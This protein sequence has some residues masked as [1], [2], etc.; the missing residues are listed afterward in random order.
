MKQRGWI[1]LMSVFGLM[2]SSEVWAGSTQMAV[3]TPTTPSSATLTWDQY[4]RGLGLAA[5]Y[6]GIPALLGF[7]AY[8]L[9]IRELE[10]TAALAIAAGL[11]AGPSAG[12]V[13]H[14]SY[15]H[16]LAA[17]SLRIFGTGIAFVAM[18]K[19]LGSGLGRMDCIPDESTPSCGAE[20]YDPDGAITFGITT[21]V[22][23][24]T[25]SL[26]QPLIRLRISNNAGTSSTH[27]ALPGSGLL[28]QTLSPM[29]KPETAGDMK[30]GLMA[31]W[32]F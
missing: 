32:S 22:L 5:L 3:S 25:Y 23:G 21:Y 12:Q 6:T 13:Y 19:S 20:P 8:D 31:G 30:I 17:T 11:L 27:K 2:L 10:S 24:V 28:P 4:G 1:P 9:G 15:G 18:I 29:V 7:Y 14:G 16:A 26:V